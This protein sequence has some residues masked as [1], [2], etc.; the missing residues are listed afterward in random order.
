MQ[1]STS[2]RKPELE[3]VP[4]LDSLPGDNPGDFLLRTGMSDTPLL[5]VPVSPMT[6]PTKHQ[7]PNR[8]RQS[9]NIPTPTTP[10]SDS[11]T[12]GTTITS[13]M[14]RQNSLCNEPLLESIQ[15]MK[16]P[17]NTSFSTDINFGDQNLY[18]HVTPYSSRHSRRSSNEEQSQLLVG[19]G[20]ASHD[21]QFSHSLSA[22]EANTAHFH[23]SDSAF[24]EKMEKSHSNESASSSTSTSSS[25]SKQRLQAQNASAAARPLMPRG[26]SDDHAMCRDNSFR[27]MTGLDSKDGSQDKIAISKPIYQ[28]PKHDRVYCTQC[29]DH[30][31]GFRGEHELRRHQDRQHKLMVKK[32]ICIQLQHNPSDALKPVVPL[33]RCKACTTQKKYGAYYN[34]A[35]HLRRAHF[36]PKAT[37]GRAKM[38]KVE[39]AQKRGGKAAGDWPLMADLKKVWMM[40]VE[41]PA[42]DFP[43]T[44]AEQQEVDDSDNDDPFDVDEH[45]PSNN[46]VNSLS[47]GSFDTPYAMSDASFGIYPSPTNT[48]FFNMQNMQLDL[49]SP[50]QQS[51][52]SSSMTF[53]SSQSSFDNFPVTSSYQNDPLAFLDDATLPIN[54]PIQNNYDD[55][56]GLVDTVNF[57]CL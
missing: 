7:F 47:S 25:R 14:S 29:E 1:R 39:D 18:D 24:G 12:T 9:Y 26:G 32:W 11:L 36:S 54:L 28:R 31:D 21:S 20:G 38:S 55:P 57:S 51:I 5:Q 2:Q 37:K 53:T 3:Q 10:M 13:N 8:S 35:A 4:E 46:S 43:L 27:S 42:T 17:S 33:H 34:A 16:F 44:S 41:E 22:V 30:L 19:A 49:S 23:S 50:H 52:D 40:E 15:M 56:F 48:E 45:F 6:I